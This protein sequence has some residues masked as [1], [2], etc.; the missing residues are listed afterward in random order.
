[1]SQFLED[2]RAANAIFV[3]ALL[4]RAFP[5]NIPGHML[6]AAIAHQILLEESPHTIDKVKAVLTQH[7]WRFNRWQ[8]SLAVGHGT[9]STCRSGRLGSLRT[10]R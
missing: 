10:F 8:D 5:W 3:A 1:M 6:S 7:P 4:E 2:R 9:T